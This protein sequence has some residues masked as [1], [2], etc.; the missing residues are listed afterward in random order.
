MQNILYVM[1]NDSNTFDIPII[2]E[3]H[4]GIVS[5]INSFHY[6]MQKGNELNAVALTL[7]ILEQYSS[8]HFAT[9][10]ALMIEADYPDRE[11]HIALHRALLD[12]TRQIASMS[13]SLVDG[14]DILKFLKDWWINHISSEDRK[15]VPYLKDSS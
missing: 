12:K 14:N 1:W 7:V 2:D 8:I 3:Q 13:Y 10:E 5:T 9:E 11:K 6:F 4:R 15:Y